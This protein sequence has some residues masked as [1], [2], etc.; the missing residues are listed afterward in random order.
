MFFMCANLIR[1]VYWF[2][3]ACSAQPWF[4]QAQNLAKPAQAQKQS[5]T[6]QPLTTEIMSVTRLRQPLDETPG[7]VT[8]IDARTLRRIGARSVFDALRLVPGMIVDQVRGSTQIASYHTVLDASGGRIQV[9]IDG[10]AV[11]GGLTLK[12]TMAGLRDLAVEDIERIEVLRG[13][14]SAAYGANA[15]LGVINIIT[16]HS[17]DTLGGELTLRAGTDNIQDGFA[18]LGWG[19]VGNSH[20]MS[21]WKS[22]DHGFLGIPDQQEKQWI[23]WRSDRHLAANEELTMTAKFGHETY[24]LGN[25]FEATFPPHQVTRESLS[26]GLNWEKNLATDRGVRF[27]AQW[28]NENYLDNISTGLWVLGQ[29]IPLNIDRD[30][31]SQ[32][33]EVEAQHNLM[34]HDSL[35]IVFGGAFQRQLGKG[36]GY[37]NSPKFFGST[38]TR[39]F[40]NVEWKPHPSWILN[41]GATQETYKGLGNWTLP[42]L[43][44]N[45]HI[46]EGHTFRIGANRSNQVPSLIERYGDVRFTMPGLSVQQYAAK[47]N[48]LQPEY[49]RV[50]EVGYL[51]IFPRMRSHFD[52]RVF[53]EQMSG[54]LTLGF[55]SDEL[56]SMG[57]PIFK[58][59]NSTGMSNRGVEIQ[60]HWKPIANWHLQWSHTRT[61][62]VNAKP[63]DSIDWA[64][65]TPKNL[66]N[67][68]L[69]GALSQNIET[70]LIFNAWDAYAMPTSVPGVSSYAAKASQRLDARIAQKFQINGLRGET[71]LKLESLLN[72]TPILTIGQQPYVNLHPRRAHLSLRLI[73]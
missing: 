60:W 44:L 7:A 31:R 53:E 55:R 32:V 68:T 14:N 66:S 27:R 25:V 3:A 15:F 2:L 48:Q 50:R 21:V 23:R 41:A 58:T 1:S 37:F 63:L 65:R 47:N 73:Y 29:T 4:A 52:V 64:A 11:Y 49:V 72:P 39:I 42:R 12:Q 9:F 28:S 62:S 46:T 8:V 57:L 36:S 35:R 69:T 43:M 10:H 6:L 40:G 51:G 59:I 19:E 26:A 20:R 5:E 13:S 22:K 71:A 54:L 45:V 18:Q 17:S 56:N 67:A 16:H 24:D 30:L 34:P 70:A 61:Q 38:N 33:F